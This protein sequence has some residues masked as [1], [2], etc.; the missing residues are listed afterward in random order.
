MFVNKL[1]FFVTIS[2]DIKFGTAVLIA[3]QTHDI[4]IKAVREVHNI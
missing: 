2:R 1:P 3:D 4:L